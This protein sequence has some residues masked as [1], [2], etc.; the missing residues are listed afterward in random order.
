MQEQSDKRP[1]P[2]PDVTLHFLD[3][4]GVLFDAGRRQLYSLNATA[5]YIWCCLE[6]GL[7]R[8]R[9]ECGL[10]Q[11]FGF[12][13]GAA[14][15]HVAA[16]LGQWRELG[17]LRQV[18]HADGIDK[19][20][21]IATPPKAAV[22]LR[23][24]DTV[25]RLQVQPADLLRNLMPLLEPL[26]TTAVSEAVPLEI[27]AEGDR[28]SLLGP[29]GTVERCRQ[30]D[31]LAPLLK[32][33]LGRFALE[34]SRDFCAI[35]AAALHLHDRCLLLPGASGSGKST[36]AA[37]LAL[38]GFGLFGDDTIV[39]AQDTLAARAMPFAICLKPG[40]WRLLR[41]R[42]P[43]L[44]R[45]PVHKRPDGKL[46]RYIA[47]AGAC[48]RIRPDAQAPVGWIVFPNRHAGS[49]TELVPLARAEALTRLLHECCPLGGGLDD[50]KVAQLVRWIGE[51]PCF[52]LRFSSLA[53]AVEQL[54]GLSP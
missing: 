5:T 42:L 38:A 36:L 33:C 28:F 26:V 37:A 24:L 54:R 31:T 9:I 43:T 44:L 51:I 34:R 20:A 29:D 52:E 25:F 1:G 47:P 14:A 7:D 2:G 15:S 17:L 23:L 13:Q 4:T 32:I 16:I 12:A 35:H 10:E 21:A 53:A 39:L 6:D 27:A 48:Q 49:R 45:Q 40:A 41:S 8:A 30:R 22:H 11:T 46:V 3:D 50:A 19:H 18:A